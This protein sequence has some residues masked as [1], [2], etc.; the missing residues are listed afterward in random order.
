MVTKAIKMLMDASSE[1]GIKASL[2]QTDN[3]NRIWARDTAVAALAII[4]HQIKPLYKSIKSSIYS[5]QKAASAKGQIPSNVAINANGQIA[6]ASFGGPVGRTDAGF[7]WVIMTIQLL[8]QDADEELKSTAYLQAGTIFKLADAWEFNGKNLMYLPM[9]SNWA[10]EYVTHGYVLY[11]QILRY[12]ALDI[13]G[14]YYNREDWKEKASLIK[15]AIKKHYL[16]ET[17]LEN[18][19]Y[20]KAQIRE[21]ANFDLE[22]QFI[23]SFSPGDRV[24]RFDC[25]AAGLLMLLNIPSKESAKKLELASKNIFNATLKKGIPAFY[26]LI[27]ENDPLYHFIEL[28]HSYHFKNYPGHFHNGGIWPVVNGFLIAGLNQQGFT[29]TAETL[30]HTMMQNLSQND[31]T[32]PFAEYFDFDNAAPGGVKNLCYSASGYLIGHQSTYEADAFKNELFAIQVKREKL[33]QIIQKNVAVIIDKIGLNKG[34]KLA[35]SIA[36]ESGCGKT[37]LSRA[38]KEALETEGKKVVILHQDEYFNLPPKQNHQARLNDFSH[39]GT[40]EAKLDLLDKHIQKIK[41]SNSQT[42]NIP[43]MDWLTDAEE[44]T[45]ID[46]F[47]VDL[48]IAEGTYTSLLCHVDQRIFINTTYQDTRENRANRNREEQSDFIEKVLKKE[49]S[50][51]SK[52]L[53]LADMVLNQNFSIVS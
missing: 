29:E 16:L 48:I 2:E 13:A 18:S 17:D 34:D 3:Y 45:L 11:D 39:I 27:K 32:F 38:I 19:L 46:I 12:W 6:G 23:A 50:I 44:D 51:I 33:A 52:H 7:W 31:E 9:S 14:S 24:E 35:I 4:A 22:H 47:G 26:P 30:Q 20:T 15:I 36:G 1:Q 43:H 40:H 10:D 28:N 21:L 49:S 41:S 8:K 53:S 5:L 25:W 42:L 37:T